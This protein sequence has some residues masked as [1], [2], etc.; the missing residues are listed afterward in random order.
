MLIPVPAALGYPALGALVFGE[1]TGLPVP[2]ETALITAGGL[3]AAGHLALPVVVV[4][5]IVAAVTGDTLGYWIGRRRGRAFLLRDGFMADHR[6]RAVTR[7]DRFFA[8]RGTATVFVS[9]FIPGVR[10]VAA[11]MAG[12]T[13]MPWR[14]FA[15]ANTLGAI[16]W[17][18][19]V[20]GLAYLLGP[21]GAAMLAVG[22]LAFGGLALTGGWWRQRR[23]GSTPRSVAASA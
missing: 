8:R 21:S 17:A 20:A 4:I 16:V 19:T 14:R 15:L 6:R 3:A 18:T 23:R 1:S 2:G 7:A 12:A 5:A 13:R 22:G 9:R 10:V 11:V